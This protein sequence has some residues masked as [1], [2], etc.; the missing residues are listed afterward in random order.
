MHILRGYCKIKSI[1]LL[2]VLLRGNYMIFQKKQKILYS[3]NSLDIKEID[4][5]I[6]QIENDKELQRALKLYEEEVKR[7]P[8][9]CYL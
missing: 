4:E 9:C 5:L 1:Q 8:L 3:S 6:K 7:N 2:V